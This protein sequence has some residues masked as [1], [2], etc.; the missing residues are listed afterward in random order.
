MRK[1]ISFI[2]RSTYRMAPLIEVRDDVED[3]KYLLAGNDD[4]ISWSHSS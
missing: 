1:E 4:K 2:V 3:Q